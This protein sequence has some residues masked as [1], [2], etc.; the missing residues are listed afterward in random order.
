MKAVLD[1]TKA[2]TNA[3]Y[4]KSQFEK[5]GKVKNILFVAPQLTSKHLYNFILPFF[6]FY[7]ENIFTA[8]TGLSKFNPFEQIARINQEYFPKSNEIAWADF[9]VIPFTTQDLTKEYGLYE[10]IREVNP[11][12]QIVFYVDFDYYE[13]PDGHPYKE[14]FEF[15]DIVKQT[16][17][18]ILKCDLCL[19]TN[20]EL[21]KF[22]VDKFNK[23]AETTYKDVEEI[24]V[25]FACVGCYI[26]PEIV[27]Q[28]V[29]FD[30]E[31]PKPVINKVNAKKIAVVAEEI[32]KVDLKENKSKG[33]AKKLKNAKAEPKK[34]TSK[35]NKV[36]ATDDK[37]DKKGNKTVVPPVT[38]PPVEE[39]QKPKKE[40]DKK[41]RV[42]VIYSPNSI[43]DIKYFR[44]TFIKINDVYGD[45]VTLVFI[46]YDY[47]EDKDKILK[48][49]NFEYTP[50][51][52]IN[53]YFKQLAS[54][55]LDFVI[56]PLMNNNFN[57][58][59]EKINKYEE[60][61]LFKIPIVAP[62][63]FPY[64]TVII[65]KNNGYHYKDKD[66][67]LK[68]LEELFKN[69]PLLKQVGEQA[70]KDVYINYT[71]TERNIEFMSDIYGR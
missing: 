61:S 8:I 5:D 38:P 51:V 30:I 42:G 62:Y 9:V 2:I 33:K 43:V 67:L 18:N 49:L 19:T 52:S 12:A 54:L 35:P 39:V 46:G 34:I 6:S 31:K 48:G 27:L 16:E 65:D 70:K 24:P 32:K 45:N 71:F 28:N 3:G 64:H 66:D 37:D 15:K 59:S 50:P 40:L 44:D 21:H 1:L 36:K 22:L 13:L 29:D 20:L 57:V 58:R 47:K 63:Q 10:A 7:N 4:Y 25:N 68:A 11:N 60:C 23:L 56:V 26:D 14:L 53:H 41:Y 17:M 55:N 69:P